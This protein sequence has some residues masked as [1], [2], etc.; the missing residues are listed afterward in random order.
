MDI[1]AHVRILAAIQT[2]SVY[3][4]REEAPSSAESHYFVVLNKD[5][6]NEEVLVLVCASSQIDKRRRIIEKLG[7]PAET[8]ICISPSEYPL[9]TKDTVIDCNRAFEKTCQSLIAKLE[10]G[11]LKTCTELMPPEIVRKLIRG[12]RIST[13]VAEKIKKVLL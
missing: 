4:F 11:K 1:P 8:L 3:Y 12:I 5:P 6:R 2:G 13:Q 9:F 7:F 10:L